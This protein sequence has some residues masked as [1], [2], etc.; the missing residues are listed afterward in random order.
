MDKYFEIR[1]LPSAE[2]KETVLLNA[3]YPK[4][5]QALVRHGRGV[6][7][8]SF[9]LCNREESLSLG[10]ILRFHGS[11]SVLPAVKSE[12]GLVGL[13]DYISISD[14]RDVPLVKEYRV[15]RRVQVKSSS[16]R[17]LR[18]SLK[19]GWITEEEAQERRLVLKD[20]RVSLPFI[21][22]ASSSTQQAFRLFIEHGPLVNQPSEGLFSSYGF[23]QTA[24]IPWF[25]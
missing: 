21:Q 2:F 7:G 18:R 25:V 24:T 15:V 6:V 13:R 1:L 23:S 5:H 16:E 9:P 14:L 17:L 3:I 20:K 22:L 10:P 19:K 11:A 8:I 4:V 12:L